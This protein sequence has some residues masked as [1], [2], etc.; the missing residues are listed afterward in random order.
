MILRNRS[1]ILIFALLFFSQGVFAQVNTE[2]K[3]ADKPKA[4]I[5]ESFEPGNGELSSL[6]I[7]NF[8]K[9]VMDAP[10]SKGLLVFYCGKNCQYGEAEANL[11]GIEAYIRFRGADTTKRFTIIS[12]GFREKAVVELWRIPENACP[13][14]PNSTIDYI[15][16][17]FK[18]TFKKKIVLYDCCVD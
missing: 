2:N 18:G 13:P 6:L 14:I 4:E 7:D 3:I 17:K 9:A 1:F 5:I 15:D 12:G 11:R 10:N 8:L 16:V